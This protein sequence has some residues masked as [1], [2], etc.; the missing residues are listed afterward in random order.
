M[1]LPVCGLCSRVGSACTY[2]AKRK[3]PEPRKGI[4]KENSAALKKRLERLMSVLES[5]I[6]GGADLE[7]LINASDAHRR[8]STTRSSSASTGPYESLRISQSPRISAPSTSSYSEPTTASQTLGLDLPIDV[9]SELI[10]IYFSKIQTWMPLLHQ[11]RFY[12]QFMDP[13]TGGLKVGNKYSL[14]EAL[15]FNGIFSLSARFSTHPYFAST[16]TRERG[17]QFGDRARVLH[18]KLRLISEEATLR[19]LQGCILLAYYFTVEG[20][21]HRSWILTGVC[22]RL[23]YELDI[24]KVDQ[25]GDSLHDANE[26][27]H[28]EERRRA[29]WLVWELDSFSSIVSQ[30]P[31]SV[32]RKRMTVHLPVSDEAW[33]AN[34]PIKSSKLGSKPADAWTNLRDSPNQNPRCWAI[35]SNYLLS[36]VFEKHEDRESISSIERQELHTAI[37]CFALSL[38]VS[39]QLK[40]DSIYFDPGTLTRSNWV[41]S[42]HLD[43]AT[44][45]AAVPLLDP[46]EKKK[47]LAGMPTSKGMT[48]SMIREREV[49]RIINQCS[50]DFINQ[51]H[52]FLAC[53]MIPVPLRRLG[54]KSTEYEECMNREMFSLILSQYADLWGIGAVLLRKFFI[55]P[56]L[57]NH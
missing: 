16:P 40:A 46:T 53:M 36:L 15:I 34:T 3:T 30:R 44:A 47:W 10:C 2:P 4:E 33:C 42:I 14:E 43:L 5:R 29:W 27:S 6:D 8:A 51:C 21:C 20:P 38:P 37:T 1:R 55:S 22:I 48:Y 23:V 12:S 18:D 24:D 26:W 45:R 9:A 49:S 19:G 57:N 50:P 32:N 52:P 7:E 17:V 31:F 25:R 28:K 35:V 56:S 54:P 41:I 11:S 13:A 39:L